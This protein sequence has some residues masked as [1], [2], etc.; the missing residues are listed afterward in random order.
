MIVFHHWTGIDLGSER[1]SSQNVDMMGESRFQRRFSTAMIKIRRRSW[2]D[3]TRKREIEMPISPRFIAMN[4]I[5]Q[6]VRV[7]GD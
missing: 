1:R 3:E 2:R 4:G 7:I 5:L 6:Y